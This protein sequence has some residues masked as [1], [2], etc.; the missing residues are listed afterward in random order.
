MYKILTIIKSMIRWGSFKENGSHLFNIAHLARFFST[1][2]LNYFIAAAAIIILN[3]ILPRLMPCDPLQAIYGNEALVS[4]TPKMEAELIRQFSLDKSW[5]DQFLAYAAG[6]LQGDLGYSYYYREPVTQV[7]M[8]ALPWTL[9][10][11]GLALI[12]STILGAV[13]GIES[14]YRRG[15]YFDRSLVAGLMFL[16][17]FPNFFIGIMM[18]LI[19]SVSLNLFPLSGASSAYAGYHGVSY[20]IDILK[21]LALPLSS[22]VLVQLCGVFLLTRNTV[23]TILEEAFILA[24][25]AKGCKDWRIKYGH[26]GRNSLLPVTTA[27]GLHIPH[28]LVR[29]I[30]IEM[31][32]SY[33]GVG[34]L[35]SFAIY[36][37]D[38]PLIQGILLIITLTVLT[39]NFLVDMLYFR[40]DPRVGY[41]H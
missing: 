23:V 20:I 4:M 21:H 9:L 14:G 36:S 29:T 31:I 41:A 18:L 38:Y 15:S 26:A 2:A 30:F 33:P 3:F 12:I 37:R 34:S 10:L 28:L 16:G 13:L 17:G 19:F 7:I 1:G 24:A 35:L 11:A 39:A 22:M 27:T 32:F 40:L 25:R 6:L 8:G 5:T